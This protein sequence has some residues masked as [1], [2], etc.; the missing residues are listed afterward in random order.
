MDKSD[1]ATPDYSSKQ[2]TV[3]VKSWTILLR[4]CHR[5]LE[6]KM[7]IQ[8]FLVK[9][10]CRVPHRHLISSQPRPRPSFPLEH[11]RDLLDSS[12]EAIWILV[13][14]YSSVNVPGKALIISTTTEKLCISCQRLWDLLSVFFL[15]TC[16]ETRAS[17]VRHGTHIQRT[18]F[19]P[20]LSTFKSIAS[21]TI[22]NQR[23]FS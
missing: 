2:P 15:S 19:N 4:M 7:L 22:Q 5:W 10:I 13:S 3:T 23:A 11:P 20:C 8:N 17:S 12:T 14:Q 21:S 18:R 9:T 6:L 16:T 1:A